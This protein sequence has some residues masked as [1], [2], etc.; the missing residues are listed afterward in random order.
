MTEAMRLTVLGAG[1]AYTDR[2]GASGACYLVAHGSTN[3]LL[4]LGQ[5]S[6]P[7]IFPHLRPE[8]L[9]A[10]VVSHL[11]P[12]HFI[13]LVPLRHYLRY[14][15]TP[16]RRVRVLGP[17]DLGRR[18]DALH[19][20]PGFAAEALELETLGERSHVVGGLVVEGRLV[21][22]TDESY[23][24]RVSPKAGGPGLVYSGDCGRAEDIAPLVR[25]DDT[26]LSEASFGA[27]PVPPG[28]IHLDAPAVGRLAA[29]TGAARALLT[30]LQMGHDPAETVAA[31][32]A[33]Y[34]GPV[35][36]V[37]PGSRITL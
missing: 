25:P 6:F 7:R 26:I 1:P 27:G 16:R 11:H 32:R 35:E 36:M 23:A 19:A 28:A 24:I 18:L 30:H 5:G 15:L 13:D 9:D 8:A 29:S 37:W 3:L 20:A 22:H 33:V 14:E 12:D 17:S 4:D 34:R 31:C 21:T 10:V 2:E